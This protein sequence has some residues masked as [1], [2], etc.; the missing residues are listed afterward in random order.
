MPATPELHLSEHA[1]AY[2][3]ALLARDGRAARGAVESAL[4]SGASIPD[5]YL[6]VLQPAL[7]AVGDCWAREDITVADEHFA[8]AVTESIIGA[9]G[10]RVRGEPSD[11]RLA[12]LTCTPEERHCIG[13]RMLSDLL[14]SEGWEVLDLGA[15][16]PAG[17]L[18]ALV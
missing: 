1:D 17:D 4:G 12:V 7:H 14:Q 2:L 9:L 13:L 10:P 11:G 3:R 5:V 15:S 16:L 6:G 18:A 8:S